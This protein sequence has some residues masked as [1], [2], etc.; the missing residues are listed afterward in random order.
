MKKLLCTCL[1]LC[2]LCGTA[3]ADVLWEPQS[4]FYQRNANQCELEQ[5]TYWLNSPDG[6]VTLWDAP[7]GNALAS[8]PNGETLHIYYR[9]Q[10]ATGSWG[11]AELSAEALE[12]QALTISGD[13]KDRWVEVWVPMEDLILQYDHRSFLED[14]A[15]EVREESRAVD[16]SGIRY[17]VYPYPGGVLR[18]QRERGGTDLPVTL[19]PLYTD[20]EGREWGCCGYLYGDRNIWLCISDLENPDLPVEDHTPDLYPAAETAPELPVSTGSSSLW[21]AGGAVAVVCGVTA[22]L[23]LRMKKRT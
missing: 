9:W 15:D 10:G 14:H 8:L 2:L 7:G 23:I 16:L 11:A 19:S 5:R 1:T 4:S 20:P 3:F 6:Y 22:F 21:L 13:F 12:E 17:C 18:Y